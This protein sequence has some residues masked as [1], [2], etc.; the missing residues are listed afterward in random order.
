[1]AAPGTNELLKSDSFNKERT[2]FHSLT[3]QPDGTHLSHAFSRLINRQATVT[4][5]LSDPVQIFIIDDADGHGVTVHSTNT[6]PIGVDVM[7]VGH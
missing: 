7:L 1:M 3:T 2:E 4:T 5:F 6:A